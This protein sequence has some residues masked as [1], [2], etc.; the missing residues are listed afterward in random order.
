MKHIV[1]I[2]SNV[3][4]CFLVCFIY[5]GSALCANDDENNDTGFSI[6]KESMQDENI[7]NNMDV[8]KSVYEI[9]RENNLNV[10]NIL[11]VNIWVKICSYIS[12][13]CLLESIMTWY[14]CFQKGGY[15]KDNSYNAQ[16]TEKEIEFKSNYVANV[17]NIL[18]NLF[19]QRYYIFDK[20]AGEVERKEI[21][22]VFK[23][24]NLYH[25]IPSCMKEMVMN[26]KFWKSTGNRE[27]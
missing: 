25:A 12:R 26:W 15:D 6:F 22:K 10:T 4:C 23:K 21:E 1:I 8:G 7:N 18:H 24:I 19:S 16:E 3:L 2:L 27:I 11:P 17:F 20:E 13:E 9:L 14:M 5:N